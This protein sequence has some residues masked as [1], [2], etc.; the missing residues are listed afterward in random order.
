[1]TDPALP[2]PRIDA[3]Q[4]FWRYRP[5]AYSW[6]GPGME[7]LAEDRLPADLLPELRA[8]RLDAAIAVQARGV[9]EETDFLLDLAAA[10]DWIVGVV[11]WE[12]LHATD[13]EA[14][15]EA[16]SGEHKLVGFRHTVQDEP[17]VAA[18][19]SNPAFERGVA[20]LQL[21]GY[22]YDVLV[23]G[24]QLAPTVE[25]CGR[26]DHHWLV[27]DHLGK[28]PLEAFERDAQAL[29]RWRA[30]LAPL[31]DMPHVACKLSGLL[32][33]ADWRTGVTARDVQHAR[34]CL[35]VA[36]DVFG[37]GRVMFGSDWPVCQLAASYGTV[38]DV[39]H[40]WAEERLTATERADLWGG[41]AARCYNLQRK[42]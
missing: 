33:E 13:L 5:E 1:M 31:K 21:W 39:L 8:Q 27:L 10:H 35:D 30:A 14:R 6:I 41:N 25:F 11:G 9:R 29:A 18:F 15:L 32:T 26:H 38:V 34:Q 4:H 2:V 22:T 23:F 36:L 20:L 7:A 16:R 42:A 19:L 40:V 37:P 28:P 17:D 12:D 24:H 3:H